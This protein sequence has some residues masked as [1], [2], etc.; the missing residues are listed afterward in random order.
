[1]ENDK[2]FSR[3]PVCSDVLK[4]LELRFKKTIT[5]I[6]I[7]FKQSKN[8]GS[9]KRGFIWAYNLSNKRWDCTLRNLHYPAQL[10][11]IE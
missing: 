10:T 7:N 5:K 6:K 8:A 11:A 4:S 9:K 2:A 1:L 3:G